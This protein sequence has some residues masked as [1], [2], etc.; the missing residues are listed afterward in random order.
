MWRKAGKKS[1]RG[2][3][4]FEKNKFAE[5]DR[6][7][8]TLLQIV[9]TDLLKAA[10]QRSKGNRKGWSVDAPCLNQFSGGARL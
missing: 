10:A 9:R 7:T 4:N 3:G 5:L 1:G 2:G 6:R 8:S